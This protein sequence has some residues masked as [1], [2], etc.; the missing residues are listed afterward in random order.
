MGRLTANPEVRQAQTGTLTC[1]FT[2]A[3]DSGQ[4]KTGE[5]MTEFIS[6]TAFNKTAEFMPKYFE[7]GSMVIVEGRLKS[8]SYTDKKYP[9]VT[10]YSTDVWVNRVSFG[11]TKAAHDLSKQNAA[12]RSANG[13]YQS[14]QN[15][16]NYKPQNQNPYPQ[17]AQAP[18]YDDFSAVV[19]TLSDFEEVISD[20]DLPF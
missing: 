12:N 7:K 9:D 20:T 19:G 4:S 8:S 1:R 16:N 11:E 10:H 6:C 15:N 18:A 14:Y 2:V 17:A 5:K 13:G 3:V